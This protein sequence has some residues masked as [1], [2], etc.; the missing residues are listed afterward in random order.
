MAGYLVVIRHPVSN[1][2]LAAR[3]ECF[4]RWAGEQRSMYHI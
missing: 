2:E 4:A 3:Q 1:Q